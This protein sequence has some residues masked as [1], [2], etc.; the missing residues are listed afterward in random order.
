MLGNVYLFMRILMLTGR[1]S[2]IKKSME[3]LKRG[4]YSLPGPFG[5]TF[6]KRFIQK[7]Y[8]ELSR[9]RGEL[10]SWNGCIKSTPGLIRQPMYPPELSM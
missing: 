8:F 7:I 3:K 1:K 5:L 10:N 4:A 2:I 9:K 6:A